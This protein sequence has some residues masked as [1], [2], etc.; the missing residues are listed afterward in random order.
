[1]KIHDIT[2][3]SPQLSPTLDVLFKNLNKY[4]NR[5]RRLEQYRKNAKPY[6][7]SNTNVFYN[8]TLI[9]DT[10]II[11]GDEN[12]DLLFYIAFEMSFR[13]PIL[14]QVWK[15]KKIGISLIPYINKYI[16]IYNGILTDDIVSQNGK[17]FLEN[18]LSSKANDS[19]IYVAKYNKSIIDK[20]EDITEI[21]KYTQEISDYSKY[22]FLITTD[23]YDIGDNI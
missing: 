15:N 6:N 16:E 2:Y 4:D 14:K 20:I 12:D 7:G 21:G 22:T 3:E 19:N 8:D 18:L 10:L 11:F 23:A 1:M 13:Y 17:T 5:L 9:D